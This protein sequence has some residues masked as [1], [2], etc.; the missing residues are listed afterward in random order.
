M[1]ATGGLVIL[2]KNPGNAEYANHGENCIAYN[3]GDLE[4]ATS[5]FDELMNNES[6][7]AKLIRGGKATA[8]VRDWKKIEPQIRDFWK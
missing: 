7:R 6:L 8:R 1:M 3:I 2:G 4:A 5:G